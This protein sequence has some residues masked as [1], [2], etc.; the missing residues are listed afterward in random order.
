MAVLVPKSTGLDRYIRPIPGRPNRYW[1]RRRVPLDLV[2]IVEQPEWRYSLNSRSE[3]EARREAIP[4]LEETDRIIKLAMAG[5]WP[6]VTDEE[7][8]ALAIGWWADFRE[9]T[10]AEIKERTGNP[11]AWL[12]NTDP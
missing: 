7:I 2:K 10:F 6:P 4:H 12:Q 5:K 3:G 9:T 11:D 1:F 8:E